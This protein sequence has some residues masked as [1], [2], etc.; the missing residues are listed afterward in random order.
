MS[1]TEEADF[2]A[3]D[4]GGYKHPETVGDFSYEQLER[5]V[6]KALRDQ[7]GESD[8][9]GFR[10]LPRIKAHGGLERSFDL[11]PVI[12]GMELDKKIRREQNATCTAFFEYNQKPKRFWINGDGTVGAEFDETF[13][14]SPTKTLKEF[15]EEN[16]LARDTAKLFNPDRRGRMYVDIDIDDLEK[17]FA[18]HG[19][20]GKAAKALGIGGSTMYMKLN[21]Q[22]AL[23]AARERGLATY[24]AEH[25][26]RN[27]AKPEKIKSTLTSRAA[28]RSVDI[29]ADTFKTYASQ[30][31]SVADIARDFGISENAV[32]NRRG[33]TKNKQAW[34]EGQL[35]FTAAK[36]DTTPVEVSPAA[37]EKTMG[38]GY[39][40]NFTAN[41]LEDAAAK[42]GTI[43]GAAKE[44]GYT[45]PNPLKVKLSKYPEMQKA[46]DRGKARFYSVN[47]APAAKAAPLVRQLRKHPTKI[48]M[49]IAE[50]DVQPTIA[51][52]AASSAGHAGVSL[53]ANQKVRDLSN[54]GKLM[55]GFDGS[56]FD[57]SPADRELL[58]KLADVMQAG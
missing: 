45:L 30:G 56:F 28:A 57:L 31:K 32:Y 4:R 19:T 18:E 7:N 49:E 25:P 12:E 55:L 21:E 58:G 42:H 2:D 24:N 3:G 10:T 17:A 33:K 54:G 1:F 52:Q 11:S 20:N 48:G 22:A 26:K 47:G 35:I 40:N 51:D 39:R 6:L 43:S 9:R 5:K 41:E 8:G 37:R 34:H 14:P 50:K 44:L 13:V 53:L 29:S 27:S 46:F 23:R 38:T 16:R 36:H 15:T